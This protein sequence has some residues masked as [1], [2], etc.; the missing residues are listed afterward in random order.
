MWPHWI[1]SAH[2]FSLRSIHSCKFIFISVLIQADIASIKEPYQMRG[3]WDDFLFL[4]SYTAIKHRWYCRCFDINQNVVSIEW[5]RA[6]DRKTKKNGDK[7]K[8]TVGVCISRQDVLSVS[9][10]ICCCCCCRCRYSTCMG[11]QKRNHQLQMKYN[12]CI[13]NTK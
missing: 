12:K 9:L 6:N 1:L 3:D 10:R 8:I 4:F 2:F 7:I 11:N 5:T 13:G